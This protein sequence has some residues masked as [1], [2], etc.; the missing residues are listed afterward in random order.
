MGQP[1][2][3]KSGPMHAIIGGDDIVNLKSL[4]FTSTASPIALDPDISST[5]ISQVAG[6]VA[7][8]GTLAFNYT[9]DA[10]SDFENMWD[11]VIGNTAVA[12]YLYPNGT[13]SSKIYLY[14]NAFLTDLG[15][16]VPLTGTVDCNI[17]FVSS[18]SN[19]FTRKTTA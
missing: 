6:Y 11:A 16:N 19:G 3:G 10:G 12:M 8:S 15:T 2:A 9:N 14:G 7:E 17:S 4:S 18:D 13:G 1:I 5:R